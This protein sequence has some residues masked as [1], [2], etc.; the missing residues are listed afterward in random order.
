MCAKFAQNLDRLEPSMA[1][2]MG[3]G[4]RGERGIFAQIYNILGQNDL[5][6]PAC[7]CHKWAGQNGTVA[8]FCPTPQ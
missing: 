6:H 4:N 1:G 7:P 8:P 3:S 5:Q 2:K